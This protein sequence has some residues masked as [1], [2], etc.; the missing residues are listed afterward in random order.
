MGMPARAGLLT[1]R[2]FLMEHSTVLSGSKPVVCRHIHQWIVLDRRG[3]QLHHHRDKHASA[4]HE[5]VPVAIA[6]WALLVTALLLLLAVPVLSAAA[7]MLFFDLN[8]RTSFSSGDNYG[9]PL[10]CNT[11]FWFFG[12]PE[13]LHP[14]PAVH[15][16]GFRK[17]IAVFLVNRFW[18]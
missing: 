7:A 14:H 17:I 18:V 8:L 9:Q 10:L 3:D 11:F 6:V 4:W 15:G 12:H 16:R 5:N 1:R 2:F 13:C